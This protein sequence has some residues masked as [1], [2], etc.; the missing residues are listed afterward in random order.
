MAPI[1]INYDADL[2]E[3]AI[4]GAFDLPDVTRYEP[5]AP[6]QGNPEAMKRAAKLLVEAQ[7]PLIIADMYDRNGAAMKSLVEL[8][9]LLAI[10]VVDKGNRMNFPNNHPL[11]VTDGARELLEQAD[12][13][14]IGRASWRERV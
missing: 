10:P 11:D 9:E 6:M 5:P 13:I 1:Y 4:T 8:A 14:Q 2:Q 12:G 3:D 7:A